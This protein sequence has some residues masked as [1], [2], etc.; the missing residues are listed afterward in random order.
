M[1]QHAP[2]P[3]L[4]TAQAAAGLAVATRVNLVSAAVNGGL[5]LLKGVV[6]WLS[7]SQ[8]LLA[9]AL[10][11][12]QDVLSDALTYLAM[13]IGR[14]PADHNHPYGHGK[15][16]TF[17]SLLLALLLVG[18]A[19]YIIFDAVDALWQGRSAP[20]TLGWAGVVVAAFSIVAN[21]FLFFYSKRAGEAIQA[22][23]LIV[24]AW[25]DRMDSLSSAVVLVGLVAAS[26]GYVWVDSVA[27]VGVGVLVCWMGLKLGKEAFDELVEGA[28]GA[29]LLTQYQA[30]ALA[31]PGV[32]G[33]HNLRARKVGHRVVVDLHV[34]VAPQLTI[35]AAHVIGDAV[36]AALIQGFTEVDEVLVHLDPAGV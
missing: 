18:G 8:A 4:T 35:A 17:S 14:Q 2:T 27:A 22:P 21:E 12:A 15:F 28:V 13:R 5:A 33:V 23:I 36:E 29:E 30:V 16:E 6:G 1:H 31:V 32:Q 10:H 25:H 26:L 3:D 9:D 20:L 34:D 24:N 19:F 11:S 7:G